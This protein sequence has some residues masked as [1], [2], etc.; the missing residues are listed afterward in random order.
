SSAFRHPRV[1]PGDDE[2][3]RHSDSLRRKLSPY[4]LSVVIPGLDPGILPERGSS[5]TDRQRL[6]LRQ[7]ANRSADAA[8]LFEHIGRSAAGVSRSSVPFADVDEVAGDGGSGGHG[9]RHEMGAALETLAALEIAVR[10]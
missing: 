5:R 10:G 1:K 4:H 9:R 7:N 6:L 8:G 2:G 3:E